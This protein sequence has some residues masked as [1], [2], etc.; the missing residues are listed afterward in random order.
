MTLSHPVRLASSLLAPPPPVVVARGRPPRTRGG[1]RRSRRLS[2]PQSGQLFRLALVVTKAMPLL[3]GLATADA[4]VVRPTL[5]LGGRRPLDLIETPVGAA[6]VADPLV[7]PERGVSFL[8]TSRDHPSGP[9]PAP[10][11]A[12]GACLPLLPP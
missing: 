3:G 12:H 6:L 2:S 11:S 9:P 4:W 5:G 7:R 8:G 10:F 1:A